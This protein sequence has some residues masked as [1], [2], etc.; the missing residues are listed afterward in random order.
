MLLSHNTKE[1]AK[2]EYLTPA[3]REAWQK[4]F[5]TLTQKKLEN[6]LL[7]L[8]KLDASQTDALNAYEEMVS[9]V[10]SKIF[11]LLSSVSFLKK[12]VDAINKKL[13]K[14]DCRKNIM[15]VTH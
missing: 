12:S 14:P 6:F 2:L 11:F 5:E 3:E 4:Y 7:T 13:E 15:L 9:G 8:K 10:N 1:K